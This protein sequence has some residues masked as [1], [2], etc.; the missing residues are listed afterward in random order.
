L[1]ILVK[2]RSAG[3]HGMSFRIDA[4]SSVWNQYSLCRGHGF[5]AT[6]FLDPE[7]Q[8]VT[9][10][11]TEPGAGQI[12]SPKAISPDQDSLIFVAALTLYGRVAKSIIRSIH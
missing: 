2:K 8:A 7:W 4:Q 5:R 10:F 9:F 6:S 11:P 12:H 1:K 3:N